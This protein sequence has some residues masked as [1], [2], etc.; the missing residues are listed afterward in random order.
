MPLVL[1]YLSQRILHVALIYVALADFVK[2]LR[3]GRGKGKVRTCLLPLRVICLSR[4]ERALSHLLLLSLITANPLVF[5]YFL[6]SVSE[7]GRIK[8]PT[9]TRCV[10]VCGRVSEE[11]TKASLISANSGHLPFAMSPLHM[12]SGGNEIEMRRLKMQKK[13][14]LSLEQNLFPKKQICSSSFGRP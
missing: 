14:F 2:Q 13:V 3:A 8:L 10:C 9:V 7:A 12:E 4:L 1:V 6:H 11:L 5:I